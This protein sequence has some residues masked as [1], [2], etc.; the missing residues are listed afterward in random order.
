MDYNTWVKV[1]RGFDTANT[2]QGGMA[3][4]VAQTVITSSAQP[5]RHGQ[6]CFHS[7]RY[8]FAS[9]LVEA[10]TDLYSVSKLMGHSTIRM[11]ER[12]SHLSPEKFKGAIDVLNNGRG[13]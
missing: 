2:P 13:S 7:L 3:H 10:S 4:S 5:G 6:A 12:Y 1:E 11:T 8:T 9:R